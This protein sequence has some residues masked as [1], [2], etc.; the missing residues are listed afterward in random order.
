MLRVFS[1]VLAIAMSIGLL[2]SA[3]HAQEATCPGLMLA[4]NQPGP[5]R[6]LPDLFEIAK[7]QCRGSLFAIHKGDQ[8]QWRFAS[9]EPWQVFEIDSVGKDTVEFNQGQVGFL[10]PGPIAA[11]YKDENRVLFYP[12]E[13]SEAMQTVAVFRPS[14]EQNFISFSYLSDDKTLEKIKNLSRT[15]LMKLAEGGTGNR[16]QFMKPGQCI[17]TQLT[18]GGVGSVRLKSIISSGFGVFDTG[19]SA[20]VGHPVMAINSEGHGEIVGYVIAIRFSRDMYSDQ[21]GIV[22]VMTTEGETGGC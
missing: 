10:K 5:L 18:R 20:R 13:M 7:A 12:L 3:T 9:G 6:P 19:K 16:L 1:F 8:Y 4:Y 15:R 22:V 17:T 14:F 2:P 11:Q 21:N